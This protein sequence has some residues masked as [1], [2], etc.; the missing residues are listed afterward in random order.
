MKE[1]TVILIQEYSIK[2]V[3]SVQNVNRNVQAPVR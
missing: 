1:N 2:N 3:I